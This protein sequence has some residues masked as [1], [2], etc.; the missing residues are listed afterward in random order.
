MLVFS[1]VFLDPSN[2]YNHYHYHHWAPLHFKWPNMTLVII[3]IMFRTLLRSI[4]WRLKR[5]G[6]T[7]KD[8][9]PLVL[10]NTE[11]KQTRE[12]GLGLEFSIE[13]NTCMYLVRFPDPH[14]QASR[15]T[16]L[17]CTHS[18]THWLH[19]YL[20]HL[21]VKDNRKNKVNKKMVKPYNLTTKN[22]FNVAKIIFTMS[23][24]WMTEIGTKTPHV[25]FQG[26]GCVMLYQHEA[27]TRNTK[28]AL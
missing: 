18:L 16:W 15:G 19:V 23:N 28:N 22:W 8:F 6:M 10:P 7:K 9:Q 25:W 4:S 13:F 26:Q 11:E 20:T 12:T 17:P 1:L 24:L 27:N 14:F 5:L 21:N 2:R 3:R